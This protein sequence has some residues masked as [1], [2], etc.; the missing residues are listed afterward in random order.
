MAL[1]ESGSPAI[2]K[3]PI[4]ETHPPSLPM[5]ENP[6]TQTEATPVDRAFVAQSEP[7]VMSG[8]S[9][10][11]WI[12]GF[13]LVNTIMI[14]SGSD[15]NFV[16]GLGFTLLADA[17]FKEYALVAFV[18][19][20]IALAVFVTIGFFSRK[21]HLWVYITGIVLYTLDALIYL[22]F[23]DWMSVAFH[24][25]ALFYLIRGAK[26]LREALKAAAVP[27]P[28]LVSPPAAGI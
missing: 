12:A 7:Q 13:S 18:I 26:V 8:A 10:F 1:S 9:W 15:R 28:A 24:G 22:M 4:K 3:N 5:A 27:P 19:D 25:L 16:I 17:I 6:F 11:W 23:Q 2:A 20:A 14:H 21:G